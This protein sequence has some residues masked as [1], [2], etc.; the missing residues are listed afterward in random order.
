MSFTPKLK[1]G[2]WFRGGND[3][4]ER[5]SP[6]EQAESAMWALKKEFEKEFFQRDSL[7]SIGCA[8]AF[9][10]WNSRKNQRLPRQLAL[11]IEARD[12][13]NPEKLSGKLMEYAKS[14]QKA[15]TRRLENNWEFEL[16]QRKLHFLAK[17]TKSGHEI[18]SIK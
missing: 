18:L 7:I 2:E 16:T 11:L 10:R 13:L 17:G 6:P 15:N 5:R 14:L 3:K 12:A 4:P 9:T 8:V 1:N